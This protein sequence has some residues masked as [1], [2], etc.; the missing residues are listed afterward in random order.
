MAA[1]DPHDISDPFFRVLY[2]I[3]TNEVDSRMVALAGGSAREDLGAY[4]EEVGYI[5]A[6]NDII[7]R[8]HEINGS[9]YERVSDQKG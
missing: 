1:F 4:R 3:L 7:N 2:P 6:L 8:C 5:A 9:L